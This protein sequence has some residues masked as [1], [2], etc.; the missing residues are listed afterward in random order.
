[1]HNIVG[2]KAGSLQNYAYSSAMKGAGF[3]WDKA[4]LDSF[5]ANA[6]QIVPGN[7][8]K[9]F[10]VLA[11]ADDRA[12]VEAAEAAEAAAM[13]AVEAAEEV[14]VAAAAA[15]AVFGLDLSESVNRGDT[16]HLLRTGVG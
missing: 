4:K 11:S 6:E 1:L 14:A 9:Q 12:K 15:V 3:T 2:R 16:R 13:E 10:C 8:M 7:N 5:I